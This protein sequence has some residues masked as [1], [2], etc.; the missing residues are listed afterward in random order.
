MSLNIEVGQQVSLRYPYG[1]VKV[2]EIGRTFVVVSPV[3]VNRKF[4]AGVCIGGDRRRSRIKAKHWSGKF[5]ATLSV[6]QPANLP[7]PFGASDG[8]FTAKL[9]YLKRADKVGGQSYY[10]VQTGEG[11]TLGRVWQHGGR[12]HASP[13]VDRFESEIKINDGRGGTTRSEAADALAAVSRR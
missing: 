10:E 9:K 5:L 12:W 11:K 4:M 7:D 3:D 13:D 6:E 1:D 8:E 2:E